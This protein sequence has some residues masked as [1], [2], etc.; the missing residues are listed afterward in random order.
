[1]EL[2]Y[3]KPGQ[4]IDQWYTEEMENL[5]RIHRYA[6]AGLDVV[7][8]KMQKRCPHEWTRYEELFY[9]VGNTYPGMR[10]NKC[11]RERDLT[12]AEQSKSKAKSGWFG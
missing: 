7:R 8:E 3:L 11:G 12:D 5:N 1:M 9:A 2:P 6:I 4:T 10:C